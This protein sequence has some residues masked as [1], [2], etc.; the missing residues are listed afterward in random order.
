MALSYRPSFVVTGD[1]HDFFLRPDGKAAVFVGD[2]SGHG[3][4]ASM[5]MAIARTILRTH[6]LH[7][8][9]GVTLT[10]LGRMLHGQLPSDLFMT[11]VYLVLDQ[12]GH[13][14]WATAGHHPPLRVNRDGIVDQVDLSINGHVLGYDP[15]EEYAEAGTQLEP[16]DRLLLFTDGL[17]DGRSPDGDQFG[18]ARLRE[19]LSETTSLPLN[20][21]VQGLVSLVEEHLDG[22]DFEDDF[23]IVAVERL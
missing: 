16:G 15:A 8:R 1:Y 17:W 13:A 10:R 12:Q 5:I 4:A 2:G 9:P 11:G 7:G 14:T 19:Y 23:T 21:A 22:V 20:E 3:P 6:D 18:R